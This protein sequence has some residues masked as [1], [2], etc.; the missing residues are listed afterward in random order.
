VHEPRST[1]DHSYSASDQSQFSLMEVRQDLFSQ[2]LSDKQIETIDGKGR[3]R[4][5]GGRGDDHKDCTQAS[6][7]RLRK[8]YSAISA[9][10]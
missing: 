10:E 2:T 5:S 6:R 8:M 1:Q 9:T 7:D 3:E 4:G